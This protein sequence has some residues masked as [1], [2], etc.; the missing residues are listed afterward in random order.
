V[1]VIK[2]GEGA[3]PAAVVFDAVSAAKAREPTY[4]SAIRR[5][6]CTTKRI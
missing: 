6:G 3:D 2:H 4:S 5:A 1:Q